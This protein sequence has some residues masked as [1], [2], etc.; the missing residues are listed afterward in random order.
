MYRIEGERDMVR[1]VDFSGSKKEELRNF[2][3]TEYDKAKNA[4]DPVLRKCE[5]WQ[6]QANSRRKRDDARPGDSNIDMPLTRKRMIQNSA[7]LTNPV[8]QQD[9]LYTCKP[10]SATERADNLAREIEKALDYI[11]DQFN[12]RE[13]L[14]DWIEQ[15]QIFPFGVIKTPFVY[16]QERFVT[17]EE[18]GAV[19]FYEFE[20]DPAYKT[21]RKE[22]D[23]GEVKY[24]VE[25]DE[26]VD[27][28]M[29][30][31]PEVI[32]FEDF[33]VP[34]GTGDVEDADVIWHR[35][36]QTPSA[37][38]RKIK[39]GIYDKTDGGQ[40]TLGRIAEPTAQR[41]R[42]LTPYADGKNMGY[43]DDESRFFEIIETYL[44]REV[45]ESGQE[46]EIIVTFD[47]ASKTILRA[48]HNF[49]QS[50][51]RPFIVH[52]YKHVIASIEGNPLTYI[53]EPLHVANSASFNQ[54]LDAASLANETLI[55][56]PPGSGFK[57]ALDRSEI[58]TGVYEVNFQPG[59]IEKFTLSQ[60]FN[61]LPELEDKFEKSAD[62]VSSLSPHSFG[63]E[64]VERPTMGGTTQLI[65][66]S[67]QPQYGQLERFR[68]KLAFL[69]K[70]MLSRYRQF[71]P[72]GLEYY[73]TQQDEEGKETLSR[74][75][76]EWP[77]H[78]I[79]KDVI[80]ETKVSSATMS[81]M[82]RKQ[83]MSAV[84]ERRSQIIGEIMNLATVA[85]DVMNPASGIAFQLLNSYQE[86]VN[87]MM[88]EFDM[89]DKEKL[90]PQLME[91]SQ[92]VQQFQQEI[93]RLQGEVAQRDQML[94]SIV[95][96]NPG[97]MPG[98]QGPPQQG[99]GGQGVG[100]GGGP[101]N[102]PPRQ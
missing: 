70:H 43:E 72:E 78:I 33:I 5:L 85:T 61:Q 38:K 46:F 71:F 48:V 11:C 90:N 80:I 51:R 89:I 39:E 10:R 19:D 34:Q 32:P 2:L 15:F 73:I 47:V 64:Q 35:T 17:W 3:C 28:R 91:V 36:W 13:L 53:L 49:Y 7:R 55:L 82:L 50:Y 98:G 96:Q 31:F 66:E 16:D 24:Y 21:I 95:G 83:E 59:E 52:Q 56:V 12:F 65:E 27:V 4:R 67:K 37:V 45:D 86:S 18:V 23:T 62:E 57:R 22:F 6:A 84:V 81:K 93:Q 25:K 42:L 20:N 76:L 77:K 40:D 88:V 94:A 68:D 79:E 44:E 99:G 29:G 30:A 74:E 60:P 54:R 69:A 8:L 58:R 97:G 14:D 100:P 101:S 9:Q 87:R 63:F 102:G 92:F 1:R 41:T 75:F 26:T